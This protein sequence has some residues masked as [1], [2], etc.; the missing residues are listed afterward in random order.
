MKSLKL[1]KNK[2]TNDGIPHLLKALAEN[3]SLISLNLAQNLLSDKVLELFAGFF[4]AGSGIKL[5]CLNQN[6]INVRN[7][8]NKVAEFKK[9]GVTVSV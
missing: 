6:N 9:L 7:A 3:G 8:K 1:L 4:Q 5:L 2:I